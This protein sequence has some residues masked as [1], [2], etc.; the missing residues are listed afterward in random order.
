M[1]SEVSCHNSCTCIEELCPQAKDTETSN[2]RAMASNQPSSDVVSG[3]G[4]CK[5]LEQ[6]RLCAVIWDSKS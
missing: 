1:M 3:H 2:L 5:L 4:A 6:P